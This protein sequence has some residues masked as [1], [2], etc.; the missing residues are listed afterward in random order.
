MKAFGY[1]ETRRRRGSCQVVHSECVRGFLATLGTLGATYIYICIYIYICAC[2]EKITDF[3]V[4][5]IAC[6]QFSLRACTKERA[7]L[8]FLCL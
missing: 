4:F 7:V 8:R 5:T 3:K 2:F 1:I 6:V